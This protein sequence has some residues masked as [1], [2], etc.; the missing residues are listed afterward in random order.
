MPLK[1]GASKEMVATNISEFHD[2][3]QYAKTKA[4]HGKATANRQAI[5]IAL[6]NTG[7]S[8]KRPRTIAE[9]Y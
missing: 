6:G 5:A 3:K 2:G 1:R 8:G 7:R 9:G 4:K